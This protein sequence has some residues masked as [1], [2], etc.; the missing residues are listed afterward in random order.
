[1]HA[2]ELGYWNVRGFEG[3]GLIT[4]ACRRLIE[5]GFI[6]RD[7]H[8]IEIQAAADNHRSRAVAERLGFTFE[9]S[10]R[11]GHRQARRHVRRPGR[12]R[13]AR[14]RVAGPVTFDAVVFDLFGTLV[15]EFSKKD[16]FQSVRGMAGVLGADPDRFEAA[17]TGSALER[18][19]GG[20]ATVEDNVRHI[21]ASLGLEPADGAAR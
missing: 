11:D 6:E 19:T 8:R 10:M 2:G 21:C 3:Q 9:A 20:F 14:A 12:L 18:Q 5:Y 17:W 16:F 4:K 7:L 13:A 15:P 1:M